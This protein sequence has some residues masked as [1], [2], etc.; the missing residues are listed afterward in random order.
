MR[1]E[2]RVVPG[3][4][5]AGTGFFVLLSFSAWIHIQA[6]RLSYRVQ[7]LRKEVEALERREQGVLRRAESVMS[8][9]RLDHVARVRLGLQV[10]DPDQLR[11]LPEV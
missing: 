5:I 11:F 8:L 6:L 3:F 4:L 2:R 9:E 7:D 10:P 1:F